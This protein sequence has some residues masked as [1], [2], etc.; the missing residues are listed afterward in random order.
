MTQ[1]FGTVASETALIIFAPCRMMPCF[2]TAVPT[3]KPGTSDEEHQRHVERVAQLHE[4]RRLVGGVDEQHAALEHRVVADD[5]DDLAV[6]PAEAD[7]ELARPQRVDLEERAL[8]EQPL[9]VAAHVERLP[10]ALRHQRAQVDVAGAGRAGARR[11]LP[12]QFD[13]R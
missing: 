1:I 7:D 13:G 2:S 5:A 11:R 8:V 4:P 12:C 3:M 6:E 9:G 10:L